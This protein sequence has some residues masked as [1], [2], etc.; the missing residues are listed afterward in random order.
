MRP[1]LEKNPSQKA[2]RVAQG[3]GLEFKPRTTKK[4]NQKKPYP[5]ASC[6]FVANVLNLEFEFHNPSKCLPIASNLNFPPVFSP[7]RPHPLFLLSLN[8][9]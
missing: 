4:T 8:L 7:L 3:V 2:G 1:Y 9:T 5:S 6:F